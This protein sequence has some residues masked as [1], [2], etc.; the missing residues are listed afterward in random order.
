M[1]FVKLFTSPAFKRERFV[2][3]LRNACRIRAV[4]VD[5][6]IIVDRAAL[7]RIPK[8]YLPHWVELNLRDINSP[9]HTVKINLFKDIG[10]TLKD[11]QIL[12]D[13]LRENGDV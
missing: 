7:N 11:R 6:G 8:Q 13:Y 2:D 10:A 12:M 5:N 4:A 3:V 1:V 9:L